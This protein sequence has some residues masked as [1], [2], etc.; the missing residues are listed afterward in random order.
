MISLIRKWKN[1]HKIKFL[2][3]KYYKYSPLT[4]QLK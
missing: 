1:R 3:E 2:K 4:V